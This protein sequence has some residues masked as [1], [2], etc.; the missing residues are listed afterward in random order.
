MIIHNEM[1]KA[2]AKSG[3]V[4]L[5]EMT[6]N[7]A[8]LMHMALGISGEVAELVDAILS[9]NQGKKTNKENIIEELG[10]LEFYIEGICQ[11][12]DIPSVTPRVLSKEDKAHFEITGFI[13]PAISLVVEAGNLLDTIK[14]KVIYRNEL[15]LE[16]AVHELIRIDLFMAIVRHLIGVDR[17]VVIQANIDKLRKRYEGLKYSNQAAQDR[18]DKQADS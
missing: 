11:G 3:E 16:K 15:N 7:D 8:H 5:Q 6:G 10:D 4:I 18:A 2:L 12:L 17:E 1:V 13:F 9:D 14:R